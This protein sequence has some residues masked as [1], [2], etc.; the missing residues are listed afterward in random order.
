VARGLAQLAAA[1][2]SVVGETRFFALA[3]GGLLREETSNYVPQ[4]IAAALVAGDPERYGITVRPQPPFA[5][6][7]A[8][9]RPLTPLAAVARAADASREEL[10][11]LNP[12]ILRGMTPPGEQTLVRLPVGAADGFAGRLAEVPA[13]ERRAFRGVRTRAGDTFAAIAAR[14]KVPVAELR[15]FN[16]SFKTVRKGKRKGTLTV[17]Q[18]FRVPTEALLAYSRPIG[19]VD[20][21]GPSELPAPVVAV[22]S[23]SRGAPAKK[24][25]AKSVAS[26]KGGS[27]K[28]ASAKPAGSKGATSTRSAKGAARSASTRSVK[29]TTRTVSKASAK[30]PPK[31]RT[32]SSPTSSARSKGTSSKAGGTKKAAGKPAANSA[33]SKA[34]AAR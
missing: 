12:Q 30:S 21:D 15:R 32:K 1:S 29:A 9:V 28:V 24:P 5:Y 6:D 20:G 11:D 4:I 3:E 23:A 16:P 34:T 31:S 18:L 2:D 26:T 25:G 10:L 17:G 33:R 14:E 19:E 22:S 7:S 8:F 13:A 27:K